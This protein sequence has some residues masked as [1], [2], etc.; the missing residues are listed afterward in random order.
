[1]LKHHVQLQVI[2]EKYRQ[3]VALSYLSDEAP[4]MATLL[5]PTP[6]EILEAREICPQSYIL[7]EIDK[8]ERLK[9]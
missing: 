7:R 1:M 5:K 3:L 6:R 4:R 9:Y 8:M 2:Y